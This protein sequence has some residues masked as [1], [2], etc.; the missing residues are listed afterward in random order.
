MENAPDNPPEEGQQPAL[1]LN[2]EGLPIN[3]QPVVEEK[4][5]PEIL[6]DM[7]NVWDVFAIKEQD[8]VSMDDLRTIMR[9][10]DQDL[11]EEELEECKFKI[12]PEKKVIKFANLK[13]VMEE[14]LKPKGTVE[15]LKALFKCLDTN[16]DGVIP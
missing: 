12:D 10:L 7:K 5:P 4:I 15:E 11:T 3:P 2:E 9:A 1:E 16:D 14:R 6:Q 8:Q 13:I